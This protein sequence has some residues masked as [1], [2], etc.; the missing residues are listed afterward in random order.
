MN[1]LAP[2][3]FFFALFLPAVII[4]YLLKLK[5]I[6]MNISST[7][8]WRKSLED[9]K[10]NTLF[11]KLKKSL[12][13]FLQLLIIALLTFA[14]VRPVLRLGGLEGQSFILMIDASASMSA[15][16][17]KPNRLDFAKRK[18]IELVND[19]S[20]GDR[21]MV[22]H[23]ARNA[24]VLSPFEQNKATLRRQINDILPT[25]ARTSITDAFRIARSA[26]AVASNPEI[27]LFSD[28]QF[29]IP[30][31]LNIG[32]AQLRYV[33]IGIS[34]ENIGIVDLVVRKD[35]S[36]EEQYEILLGIKNT[37]VDAK[38]VYVELWGEG[39]VANQQ[40][41]APASATRTQV[42]LKTERKLIDAQ[43]LTINGNTHEPLLFKDNGSFPEKIEVVIDSDDP[44]Q[45]DNRAWAVI[46][47]EK[48]IDVLLV[49]NGNFYLQRV[50]NLNPHVNLFMATPVQYSRPE[51]YDLVVF[52]AFTPP[53]LINGNYVFINSVPPLPDWTFGEELQLPAI[54]DWDH[55]HPLTRYLNLDNLVINA[56]NNIGTPPWVEVIAE[57]R[58]T[59]LILTFQQDD[60]RGV[61]TNFDV[62][63]SSWPM[64]VSYPIF[65]TNLIN[66]FQSGEGLASYM[67]K[68]GDML[69]IDPPEDLSLTA[70]IKLPD[71]Q[72][73]HHIEFENSSP[74][75][76]D[77]TSRYGMYEYIINDQLHKRYA[78]NLLSPEESD[79]TPKSVLNIQG[80]EFVGDESVVESNKEIWRI[81]AI[82]ALI[83]LMVEWFVYVKRA[84]YSF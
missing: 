21:M 62:H 37:G 24:R 70:E 7:L 30:A 38:E 47:H 71:N 46:P 9:L 1:F 75:Y 40:A 23:F 68:T 26:A 58:E 61:V 55:L 45:I 74:I 34:T 35:F 54:V 14:I 78:F 6:D 59:P 52:D 16:D 3:G 65:F 10:A 79:I 73:S 56:C 82:I 83:I 39:L 33:P 29:H 22:V 64:Q 84:R 19:M 80:E 51:D 77:K 4:L 27:V 66:W 20:V 44:L 5:R 12:L 81:I 50:L 72:P 32:Q 18:A 8:L 76:F 57:S 11:Q 17:V 53:A 67:K 63:K 60:I 41:A 25:D 15:T 31:D 13:L 2:I 49:T 42:L 48:A 69:I 43:K 36:I 28:G